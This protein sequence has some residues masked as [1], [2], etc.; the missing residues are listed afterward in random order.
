MRPHTHST[1]KPLL[2]VGGKP[3]LGHIL[4]KVVALGVRRIAL[5]VGYHGDQILT[6]GR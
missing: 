5:V 6:F 2:T 3:I 4:D 1:P